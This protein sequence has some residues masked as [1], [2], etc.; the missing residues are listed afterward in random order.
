MPFPFPC[1]IACI[2]LTTVIRIL[3]VAHEKRRPGY[4]FGRLKGP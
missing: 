1:S 4:W 2:D 3:A